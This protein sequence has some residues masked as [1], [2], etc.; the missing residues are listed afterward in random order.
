MKE[1]INMAKASDPTDVV[2]HAKN[3]DRLAAAVRD[4]RRG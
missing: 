4:P 3:A 1:T 2:F